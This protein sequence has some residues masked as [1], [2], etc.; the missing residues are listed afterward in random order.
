MRIVFF[1]PIGEIGGAERVLLLL[2][3]ELGKIDPSLERCLILGGDGPLRSEAERLGVP[4][5]VVSMPKSLAAFGDSDISGGQGGKLRIVRTLLRAMV[6]I[7]A[8]IAY[9][10]RLRRLLRRHAP[11]I[12]HSNGIKSHLAA[13]LA[14]P[15]RTQVIWHIHDFLG[16]RTLVRR[17]M[18]LV[19]GRASVAVA[20]SEAVRVDAADIL[21]PLEVRTIHNGVDL[22]RFSPGPGEPEAL[23]R[24]A[25][26]NLVNEEPIRVGLVATYARWKGH[27]TF[28]AAAA[29]AVRRSPQRPLY[30]Y[31]VGGPIYQT[32]GSQYSLDELRAVVGKHGLQERVG[33]VPFQP[34]TTAVYR[35]LDVVV[36]A[37]TRREPFGLTIVEAMA[38]G[39]AVIAAAGGGAAEIAE[40][41]VNA[42]TFAPGNVSDLASA[43]TSLAR[44]PA[45]RERLGQGGRRT[46]VERFA[47]VSFAQRFADLYIELGRKGSR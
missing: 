7:P 33:F 4:T 9:L 23:D 30:F 40:P 1:N 8:T 21:A 36:H 35:A 13:A 18:R 10:V 25:G 27:E 42:L 46:S 15:R 39:R 6:A 34:D 2:L 11:D 29:E 22:Q 47:A 44:D 20:N 17:L 26:L 41:G 28:L 43:M 32:L 14:R 24:L 45:E 3:A 12:L 38:C 16:D 5:E 19:A 31:L 37:S